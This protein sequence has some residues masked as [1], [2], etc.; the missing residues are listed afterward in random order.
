[1]RVLVFSIAAGGGHGKAAEAIK[2][3]VELE[4]PDS[5]VKI[6]DTLKYVN[7]FIDK[8]VVG[9]YLNT[10]KHKPSLFGKLY[11]FAEKDDALFSVSNKFNDIISTKL[12]PLIKS[13][14]PDILI[15]THP[16]CSEMISILK[17]KGKVDIPTVTVLTDHAPHSFWLHQGI[18]AFVVSN[19]DMMEEMIDR[20]IEKEKIYPFGIPVSQEFLVKYSAEE[21]LSILNLD[22]NKPTILLMGG[23]L[24]LGHLKDIYRDL[25]DSPLDFQIIVISGSNRKLYQELQKVVPNSKKTTRLLGFTKDVPRYMQI[26]QLLFTKPGGLTVAEALVSNLPLILFSPIPGQE[27]RNA[28]YLLRHGAAISMDSGMSVSD[29]LD[30]TLNYP[31]KLDNLRKSCKMLAKPCAGYCLSQLLSELSNAKIKKTPFCSS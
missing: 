31:S 12:M 8:I 29:I 25:N 6:L 23:T 19:E 21:T 30:S 22:K 26:S 9:S 20:G 11:D 1:M 28:Q 7:P 15:A 14:R 24:G 18:D 16:F 4:A 17:I 3:Y 5:S 10:I 27:E 2:T 13:F